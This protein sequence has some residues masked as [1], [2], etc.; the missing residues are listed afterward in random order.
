MIIRRGLQ[1]PLYRKMHLKKKNRYGELRLTLYSLQFCA[2]IGV[3]PETIMIMKCLCGIA[4][5]IDT[6]FCIQI[7]GDYWNKSMLTA[8]EPCQ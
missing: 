7:S 4:F 5:V 6:I 3:H 2:V 1:T 8:R